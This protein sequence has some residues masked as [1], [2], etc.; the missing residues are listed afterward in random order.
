M[1]N[2]E[3]DPNLCYQLSPDHME[4]SIQWYLDPVIKQL[5]ALGTEYGT[6]HGEVA[7]AV[8]GQA[9]G[10]FGG[11]GNDK[12]RPASTAF[13][14]EVATQL[15]GLTADQNALHASLQ[16]YRNRLQGHI[17]W[18]RQHEQECADRFTSLQSELGGG[19]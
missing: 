4:L 6:A 16:E 18:A 3:A 17:D 14:S 19:V 2:P 13:L 12:V 5:V 1:T 8:S 15:E 10:W 7:Q 11:A 9:P